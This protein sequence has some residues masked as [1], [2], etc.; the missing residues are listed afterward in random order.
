MVIPGGFVESPFAFAVRHRAKSF[1]CDDE[2]YYAIL[3]L[4]FKLFS[5]RP[6]VHSENLRTGLIKPAAGC[7]RYSSPSLRRNGYLQ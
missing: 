5:K 7:P 6:N 3:S 2:R 1:I 4:Y